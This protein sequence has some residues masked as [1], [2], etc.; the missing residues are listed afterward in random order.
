MTKDFIF[1]GFGGVHGLK[2]GMGCGALHQWD[3][4][5][6]D[7]TVQSLRDRE[8]KRGVNVKSFYNH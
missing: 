2:A 3:S 6:C 8:R 4:M 7:F 5:I 1:T